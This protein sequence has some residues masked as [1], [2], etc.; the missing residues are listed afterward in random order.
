MMGRTRFIIT[1]SDG[2]ITYPAN[3]YINVGTTK[4]SIINL[5]YLGTCNG[6]SRDIL[7]E[8]TG[9]SVTTTT[10]VTQFPNGLDLFP[11]ASVYTVDVGGAGTKNRLIV[12]RK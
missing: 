3:H 6:C 1:G 12:E 8:T 11:T 9:N 7:D 4:E 5:T 2:S 10:T